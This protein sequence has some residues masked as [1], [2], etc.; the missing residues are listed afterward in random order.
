MSARALMSITCVPNLFS[1]H[2]GCPEGTHP[3]YVMFDGA[4]P[5]VKGSL[6][7]GVTPKDFIVPVGIERRVYVNEVYGFVGYLA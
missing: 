3:S 2:R 7:F 6:L 1:A 5:V 4:E